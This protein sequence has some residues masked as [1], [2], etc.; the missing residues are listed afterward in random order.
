MGKGFFKEYPFEE[1]F[2][3]EKALA[4]REALSMPLVMLGGINTRPT[5]ERAMA[6]GFEFVAMARALLREPDLVNRMVEG[7]T[8]RGPASTA[9]SACRRRRPP[10]TRSVTPEPAASRYL[11]SAEADRPMVRE[12]RCRWATPK[13]H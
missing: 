2:L 1:A 13:N 6:E 10:P 5:M 3:R 9:T 4:F 11:T 8:A 7:D 12:S